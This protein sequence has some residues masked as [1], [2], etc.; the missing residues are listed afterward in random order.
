MTFLE[1]KT[2]ISA[3]VVAAFCI[4]LFLWPILFI[5]HAIRFIVFHR[6]YLAE[7]CLKRILVFAFAASPALSPAVW[8]YL[9]WGRIGFQG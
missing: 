3:A 6:G 2:F 5:Y 1:G 4:V 8:I 9:V 7:L